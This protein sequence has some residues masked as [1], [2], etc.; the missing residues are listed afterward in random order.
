MLP[1]KPVILLFYCTSSCNW[2]PGRPQVSHTT[3]SP[4]LDLCSEQ[5]PNPRNQTELPTSINES[6]FLADKCWSQHIRTE[7][8]WCLAAADAQLGKAPT[9]TPSTLN[10]DSSTN[11]TSEPFTSSAFDEYVL[12]ATTALS[13]VLLLHIIVPRAIVILLKCN[14]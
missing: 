9:N 5:T 11:R 12:Q 10:L 8:G 3:W 13:S 2:A 4:T 14:F 7:L 6:A 1:Y